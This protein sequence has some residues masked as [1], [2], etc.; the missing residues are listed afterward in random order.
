VR[1][2]LGWTPNGVALQFETLMATADG[3]LI[4]LALGRTPGTDFATK[5]SGTRTSLSSEV[6][7]VFEYAFDKL[8]GEGAFG[9][10]HTRPIMLINVR[11]PRARRFAGVPAMT[12]EVLFP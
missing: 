8:L 9:K 5:E 3:P 7:Q 1:R 2:G 12:L 11:I 10:T 6:S 4:D